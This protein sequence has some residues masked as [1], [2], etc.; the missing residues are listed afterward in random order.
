VLQFKVFP[1]DT[2]PTSNPRAQIETD[3]NFQEGE[4]R[5][6]GFSYFFPSDFPTKLPSQAWVTLGEQA[7]GPPYNGAGGTS[8]RVQNAPGTNDAELRWQRNDVYAWDM[9]WRGPKIADVKGKWV[10]IVQRIKLHRDSNVGFVELYMNTGSG[11]V[12]QKLAGQNRL[13]MSTYDKAN[14]GG[15]NNSRLSLYYRSDIPGPL[16]LFHG[17]HKIA[18]AGPGAFEAV[19]PKSY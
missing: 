15:A 10:D 17:S 2:G 5:Y 7:Y 13:Y 1:S 14:N 6:F 19:D 4:D 18:A 3:Y 12:Q 11:W 16:T 9:P 8:L